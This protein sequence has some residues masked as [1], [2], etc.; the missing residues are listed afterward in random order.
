M[1]QW[2]RS[3]AIDQALPVDLR[4]KKNSNINVDRDKRI[5]AISKAIECGLA[6]R[7]PFELVTNSHRKL[8]SVQAVPIGGVAE[9]LNAAVLKTVRPSR[10]S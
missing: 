8:Q 5:A 1:S 3:S 10:V 7:A 4:A 9:W 6:T 2:S